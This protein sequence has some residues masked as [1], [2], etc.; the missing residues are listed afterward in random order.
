MHLMMGGGF[1]PAHYGHLSTLFNKAV[2]RYRHY[3]ARFPGRRIILSA[4]VFVTARSRDGVCGRRHR[5]LREG[6][7][8]LGT[9]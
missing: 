3:H 1:K 4:A 8:R 6:R 5:D 7:G 2:E 9:P